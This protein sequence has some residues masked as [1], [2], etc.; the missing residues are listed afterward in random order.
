MEALKRSLAQTDKK[1]ASKRKAEPDRRQAHLLLPVS[2]GGKPRAEA[3]P[4]AAP[5]K[6]RKK[7]S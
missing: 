6:G 2:G 1:P 5:A 7:A 4:R 3:A